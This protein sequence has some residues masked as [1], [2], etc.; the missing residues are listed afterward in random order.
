[1]KTSDLDGT[2]LASFL[3]K[4]GSTVHAGLIAIPL[5]VE[6]GKYIDLSLLLNAIE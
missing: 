4:Y 5:P 2:S 1:M 6:W 3:P